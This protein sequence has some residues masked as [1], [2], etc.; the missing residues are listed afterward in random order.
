MCEI[1]NTKFDI[2]YFFCNIATKIMKIRQVT[3]NNISF[4]IFILNASENKKQSQ[5]C[6]DTHNLKSI[7]AANKENPIGSHTHDFY[8]ISWITAGYGD[9]R[10]DMNSYKI[11]PNTILLLKPGEFHDFYNTVDIEGINF[12]FTSDILLHLSSNTATR[13]EIELFDNNHVIPVI[14]HE[15][16]ELLKSSSERLNKICGDT[17]DSIVS[18]EIKKLEMLVFLLRL[19]ECKEIQHNTSTNAGNR[20]TCRIFMQFK[21]LV[22]EK[23]QS[24]HKVHEYAKLLNMSSKHLTECVKKSTKE[25][26]LEII[27]QRLILQ[28]KR[29]LHFSVLR[30]KEIAFTLGFID[31][32]HFV[33]FFKK[34]TGMTPS[35]YKQMK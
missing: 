35:E 5:I 31:T 28:S 8:S 16:Q 17:P 19:L 10:V 32:S 12:Y 15:T 11:Y 1:Y 6:V 13:I 27:N 14:S 21:K 2:L 9:Y 30:I 18:Q 23:Y 7:H 4:N 26:P 22:D 34:N 24:L 29:L 20:N 33:K 25:S 3:K